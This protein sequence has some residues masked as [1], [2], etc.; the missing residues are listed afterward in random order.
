MI[1]HLAGRHRIESDG[2]IERVKREKVFE[3]IF[4]VDVPTTIPRIGLTLDSGDGLIVG[5]DH[6]LTIVETDDG[7][8][9]RVVVRYGLEAELS[10]SIY[11]E[12]AEIAIAEG[13][14]PPG[15]WSGGSVFPL[16]P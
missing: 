7:P 3:L 12:L 4:A 10:R 8:S 1:E 11:Y 16:I 5:P 2:Q 15:L 14:N 13:H 6:P 9:P